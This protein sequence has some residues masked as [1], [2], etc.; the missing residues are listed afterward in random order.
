MI[1]KEDVDGFLKGIP[2]FMEGGFRFQVERGEP[3]SF[4][5]IIIKVALDCES[6]PKELFVK[7]TD[8]ISEIK[9]KAG[10]ILNFNPE[11]YKLYRTD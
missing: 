3:P 10:E 1:P 7:E 9:L 5:L 8:R 6:E 11:N 4:G 2:E